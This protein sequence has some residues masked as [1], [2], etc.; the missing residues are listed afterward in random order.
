FFPHPRLTASLKT[1]LQSPEFR[2]QYHL[3]PA[4]TI[5]R[6]LR[7][8]SPL[9]RLIEL[10]DS[11]PR[12]MGRLREM[13]N[14]ARQENDSLPSGTV[15][16][17][18][19][20]LEGCGRFDREWFAPSGGFWMAVAWADT[21]LPDFARLLPL[22]AGTASC[23]AIRVFGIDASIKWV[24][25]IHVRGR[26]IGGVL[27]ETVVGEQ[28]GDRYHFVG[29]GINCNN[30]SFPG[31]LK[32]SAT[33]MRNELH[34]AVDLDRFALELL[35][36]LAWNFGLI[37]LQEEQ[38]LAWERDGS[39]GNPPNPVV[40]AWKGMTDTLGRRV[41]YGYDVVRSPMYRAIVRDIDNSGGL[42]MG[43]E[44]GATVIENSGEIIYLD[45]EE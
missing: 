9:G 35:A 30:T 43:L 42:V 36:R 44:N 7:Y 6:V 33:S 8:G 4:E 45:I 2:Q 38:T 15:V 14:W 27:C 23:E 17:A 13:I 31:E 40:A 26:K 1:Y 29:I 34:A 5:D 10:H 18:R 22:A 28:P 19:Q 20:L 16:I 41:L 25:D 24:N 39:R 11:L 3:Y 37:H 21:L 12:C 32:K